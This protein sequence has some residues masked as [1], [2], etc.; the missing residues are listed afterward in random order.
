MV[1][2]VFSLTLFDVMEVTERLCL[3][4]GEFQ[5][6]TSSA[7]AEFRRSRDFSDVT[8][9]CED[10]REVEVH[11][12]IL[13]SS[14]SFFKRLFERQKHPHPFIFMRGL[15]PED[16]E[17]LV[18]FM[19]FGEATV[20]QENLEAFMSLATEL[21]VKGLDFGENRSKDYISPNST[22]AKRTA[23]EDIE[24]VKNRREELDSDEDGNR[25][26]EKFATFDGEKGP[27]RE[28][29]DGAKFQL[30]ELNTRIKSMMMSSEN[31]FGQKNERGR[32]CKVCGK[33]GKISLV[34]EHIE[35]KHISGFSHS[36]HLCGFTTNTRSSLGAH[37]RKHV[38][39]VDNEH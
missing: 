23:V 28:F 22:F 15:K 14:S 4:W 33:E 30:D 18:D 35:A 8:L 31:R 16:L 7:F 5:K 29:E 32:I 19:Y 38:N 21:K 12:I 9:A 34:M 6:H 20:P 27:K 1:S 24:G 37:K 2:L 13:A 25:I 39:G 3:R 11:K 36:C 17:A 10:G 26:Q